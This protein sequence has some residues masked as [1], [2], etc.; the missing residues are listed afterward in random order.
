MKAG[1][2]GSVTIL[3]VVLLPLLLTF[4]VGV[5][6]IGT[7][8]VLAA[9][10]ASAAD[11]ASLTAVADQDDG[12]LATRGELRLSADAEAVARRYFGIAL[13]EIAPHLAVSPEAAAAQ[14]A[15]A[16]FAVTPAIDPLTGWRYDHPTVRIVA[17]VPVRVP[18]FGALLLPPTTTVT[19]RAASA[20]R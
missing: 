2:R 15:V 7:V 9:R 20:A 19:V 6:Q 8:R 14:A 1:D 10:V 5:I 3:V 13:M 4:F 12:A 16:A 11:L 18:A 17:S